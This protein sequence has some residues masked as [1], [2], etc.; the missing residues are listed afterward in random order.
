VKGLSVANGRLDGLLS[1][2]ERKRLAESLFLD[3]IVKLP[4]ARSTTS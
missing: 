2:D 4:P 3:L 1:Q